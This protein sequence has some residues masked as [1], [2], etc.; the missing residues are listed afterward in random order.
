MTHDIH[1]QSQHMKST[2]DAGTFG[3]GRFLDLRAG[4]NI[5]G[6]ELWDM[7]RKYPESWLPYGTPLALQKQYMSYPSITDI[8][9]PFIFSHNLTKPDDLIRARNFLLLVVFMGHTFKL[10][11]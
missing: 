5:P 8:R 4:Q 11:P 3:V 1:D 7:V 2:I 10:S 6:F 9:G